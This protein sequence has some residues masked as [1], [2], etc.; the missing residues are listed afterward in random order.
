MKT[1]A[2][3]VL[4]EIISGKKLLIDTNSSERGRYGKK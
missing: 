3:S 2:P 1:I 4:K